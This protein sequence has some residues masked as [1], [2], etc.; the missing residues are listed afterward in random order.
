ME[1]N[2]SLLRPRSTHPQQ[3]LRAVRNQESESK[4]TPHSQDSDSSSVNIP[5][6]VLAALLAATC[7]IAIVPGLLALNGHDGLVFLLED[8]VFRAL[9]SLQGFHLVNKLA[10]A[11]LPPP[12][13]P[14]NA[15]ARSPP[16]LDTY[17]RGRPEP[18]DQTHQMRI[19]PFR[20]LRYD[21]SKVALEQVVTQPYDK[22]SPAMQQAY[23]DAS[24]YNLIRVILGKKFDT[25]T[26]AGPNVYTRAADSLKEWRKEAILAEESEPAVYGYEQTLS[27]PKSDRL[28]LFKATRTYCEQIY[29]LYSDP[30]FSVEK[31]IFGNATGHATTPPDQSVTD[32]YGV[33]HMLWKVTDPQ[34]LN[35]V[36]GAMGDKK[37]IIAD[38]H[39]RYETSTAYAR[40]RAAELGVS[41]TTKSFESPSNRAD[42]GHAQLPT[43]PFPEA[44]MMMTLVNMDA[45]GI[46][47][48]PTHRLVV[49]LKDFSVAAFLERAKPFFEISKLETTAKSSGKTDEESLES[50]N[51]LL[52]PLN[53]TEGVAMIAATAEGNYLLKANADAI[54]KALSSISEKQRQL[55][56]VQLHALVLEQ[57]LGLTQESIR[58]QENLRY[59]RSASDAVAKVASGEANVA[60]L[61]KP[62]TLDQLRDVSLALDVM[63]Q[64][65][66]DFYPKLLSGLAFYA[67][68]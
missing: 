15:S 36:V 18:G 42:E 55:D 13:T 46:T 35:L 68:D 20:A 27:K 31:L 14:P 19:Y 58:N 51:E 6:N 57:L 38:G 26:E 60:F 43:P 3:S 37:L 53:A 45:P 32:E 17:N 7:G 30:S 23:Y 59:L 50:A 1:R 65:S 66:T 28:N 61:I 8:R 2:R 22:I 12:V 10:L 48:L 62:V 41:D 39:H 67:L 52:A 54:S 47:I 44:A 34:I 11:G 21:T 56:V 9:T 63:P 29:M 25:D 33:V 64:K 4:S 49:E 40:E 16:P 24:P 5:R